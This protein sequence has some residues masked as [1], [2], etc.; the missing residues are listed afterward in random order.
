MEISHIPRLFVIENVALRNNYASFATSHSLL[1]YLVSYLYQ[2]I[3]H[4]LI[5]HSGKNPQFAG[6]IIQYD[7]HDINYNLSH[8]FA[9][10]HT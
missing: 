4:L 10:H 6:H 7:N 1:Q 5:I 3:I 2:I 9:I 8:Q